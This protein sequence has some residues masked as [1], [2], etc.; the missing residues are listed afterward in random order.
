M[1]NLLKKVVRKPKQYNSL[2]LNLLGVQVIRILYMELIYFFKVSIFSER[3]SIFNKLWSEG[4]CVIEDFLDQ[5]TANEIEKEFNYVFKTS[6]SLEK[7]KA[8]ENIIYQYDISEYTETEMA[9][10]KK[11]VLLNKFLRKEVENI[12]GRKINSPLKC[13]AQKTQLIVNEGDEFNQVHGPEFVDTEN[14]LH[15]DHVCPVFKAWYYTDDVTVESGAFVYVPRSHKLSL[16]ELKYQYLRSIFSCLID[17]GMIRWVPKKYLHENRVAQPLETFDKRGYKEVPLVG[18]KN[19]LVIVNTRGLHKRGQFEPGHVR[20][21]IHVDFR[22]I[23]YLQNL[24]PAKVN[25][26]LTRKIY[27]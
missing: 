8:G 1:K 9:Q 15:Q 24:L 14:T 6:V 13:V 17:K 11:Y 21:L 7:I 26:I 25:L 2:V 20:R 22:R 27:G 18:K 4:Y 10:A 19:S 3:T 12:A 5:E 16:Y 23:T